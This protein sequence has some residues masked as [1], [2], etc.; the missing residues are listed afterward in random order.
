M[1]IYILQRDRGRERDALA[2]EREM[3]FNYSLLSYISLTFTCLL[4]LSYIFSLSYFVSLV[5][6]LS[7]SLFLENPLPLSHFTLPLSV[8][9]ACLSLL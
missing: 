5:F 9:V 4:S 7:H 6:T 2:Y 8:S 3:L 1:Y